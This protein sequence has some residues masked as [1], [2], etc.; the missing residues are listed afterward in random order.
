[1]LQDK[2][3]ES[4]KTKMEKVAIGNSIKLQNPVMSPYH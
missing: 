2:N 4:C 1:L 3:G